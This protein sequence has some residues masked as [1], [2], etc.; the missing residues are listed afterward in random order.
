MGDL[1][2]AQLQ[3]QGEP[4]LRL[5]LGIQKPLG[6]YLVSGAKALLFTGSVV[7]QIKDARALSAIHT[8]CFLHDFSHVTSISGF[9]ELALA[10]SGQVSGM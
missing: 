8:I 3:V 1:G 7:L 6:F 2:L 4:L 10:S 9:S 5:L